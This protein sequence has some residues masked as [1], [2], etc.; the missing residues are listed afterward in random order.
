MRIACVHQGYELYGSDRSFI[1]SVRAIRAAYPAAWIEVVLPRPGPIV[2]PLR[3]LASCIVFERIWV[4]RR[5]NLARL[6]TSGLLA[7]PAA[8]V[9]AARRLSACDLVYVN[10]TVVADH[11]LA[12]RW[13]PRKAVAHVHEIPEGLALPV[14]RELLSWSGAAVIF[15]SRASRAAFGLAPDPGHHVIYNGIAGPAK[16]NAPAY[17]GT[18]PLRVL[19][20]GRISRIKG[21]E[22]LIE[23]LGMLPP[24]LR[25]RVEV[26][27]VGS[28]FEDPQ[29]EAAVRALAAAPGLAGR[30][31]LEPFTDDPAPLFR[32]A[33]IVAVPSRRPESLG[34]VAIEAMAFSRPVLASAIGGLREIVEN[35]RTGWLVAPDRPDLLAA[36]LAGIVA[37]PNAWAGF[38]A[39][40][41]ARFEAV[42]S[43][44]AAAEAIKAVAD[45]VL[46]RQAPSGGRP[47]P[48]AALTGDAA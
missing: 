47:E 22:V 17:D 6:A 38:G 40:A 12:A 21:Q 28:A 11:L 10:T 7:L 4:L 41:R 48:A 45:G 46:R 36:K 3:A 44:S 19:M 35:N 1:E 9:R 37:A 2:E 30:V 26:R 24:K 34:R 33:D 15:N 8:L 13:F 31:S 43:E 29:R 14:L 42:F 16:I 5:R 20:L 18:R 32:W 23:A 39:E 27:I 25:G